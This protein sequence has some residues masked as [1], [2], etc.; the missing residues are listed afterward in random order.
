MEFEKISN[1]ED[2][3]EEIVTIADYIVREIISDELGF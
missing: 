3:Q 2:G 1:E